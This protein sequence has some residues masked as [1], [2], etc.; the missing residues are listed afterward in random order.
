LLKMSVSLVVLE[1][2]RSEIAIVSVFHKNSWQRPYIQWSCGFVALMYM[3]FL[4]NLVFCL[5]LHALFLIYYTLL[6]WLLV[7]LFMDWCKNSYGI[8]SFHPFSLF[9][10][11]LS[12]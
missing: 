6:V 4:P 2:H 8:G 5:N 10:F 7:I 12:N 11:S 3:Y 1:N 9:P